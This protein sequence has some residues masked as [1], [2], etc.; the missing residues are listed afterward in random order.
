MVG[1][2]RFHRTRRAVMVC[3]AAAGAACGDLDS[4]AE[5][6]ASR[7]TTVVRG[8][9]SLS[10]AGAT[11]ILAPG[12][13]TTYTVATEAA[14]RESQP[15]SL[16]VT[17]LP[18]GMTAVLAPSTLNSGETAVLE[19]SAATTAAPAAATFTVTAVARKGSTRKATGQ[20]TIVAA[21]P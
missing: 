5:A 21:A 9:F 11:E 6:S 10:V 18:A 19:L 12:A 15:L 16:S 2:G 3:I 1:L 4:T 8:D 13:S 7:G 20:V 14:D 17:G